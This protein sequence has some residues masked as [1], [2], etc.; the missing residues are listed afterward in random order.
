M[1][2]VTKCG[3]MGVNTLRMHCMYACLCTHTK[4]QASEAQI[5]HTVVGVV[6]EPVLVVALSGTARRYG[7][8]GQ[9]LLDDREG[10]QTL[11]AGDIVERAIR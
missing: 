2:N 1:Y 6:T 4:I 7:P 8:L 5:T 11:A 9:E 3:K 10:G